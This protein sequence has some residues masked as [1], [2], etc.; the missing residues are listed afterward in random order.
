M[1]SEGELTLTDDGAPKSRG[2]QNEEGPEHKG[3]EGGQKDPEEGNVR[4]DR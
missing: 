3:R 2:H 1:D 4:Q